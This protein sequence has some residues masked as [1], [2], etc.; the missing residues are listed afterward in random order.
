VGSTG[1]AQPPC[2]TTQAWFLRHAPDRPPQPHTGSALASG[3]ACKGP[4]VAAHAVQV[5]EDSS[6]ALVARSHRR[7]APCAYL[8]SDVAAEASSRGSRL[9]TN[10]ASWIP[11]SYSTHNGTARSSCEITSGGVK[12]AATMKAPTIT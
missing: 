5:I 1:C 2:E 12:M 9:P 8:E 4:E 6:V 10:R 3:T 11:S 7:A